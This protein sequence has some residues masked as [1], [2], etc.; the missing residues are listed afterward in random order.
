MAGNRVSLRQI[1]EMAGVSVPTVSQILNNKAANYSSEAT[2]KKVL[3]TA[4]Q[5]NYRP[6]FAYRLMQGKT[7]NTAAILASTGQLFQEE[8]LKNLFIELTSC[9]ERQKWS[10]YTGVLTMSTEEN[11]EVIHEMNLRGVEK[12]VLIGTPVGWQDI[13]AKLDEYAIPYIGTVEKNYR[14]SVQNGSAI[15][16][17]LIIRKL[18]ETAGKKLKL[19][20]LRSLEN[21]VENLPRFKSLCAAYPELTTEECLAMTVFLPPIPADCADYPAAACKAGYAA[22]Q[23][24]LTEDPETRAIVFLND[25]FAMGGGYFLMEHP[26]LLN[27]VRIAGYNNN[28]SLNTFPVPISSGGTP[29]SL[30]AE[31]IVNSLVRKGCFDR[32]VCPVLHFREMAPGKKNYPFWKEDIVQVDLQ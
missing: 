8:Y 12:V 17:E 24:I 13:T 25:D 3:E 22:A 15:G 5:L 26:E 27:C 1:A 14:R 31:E 10:V 9:F 28:M 21:D 32:I 7:T 18:K 6:S 19:V 4:R 30:W 16:V 11:I 20:C 23:K 2:R 29:P